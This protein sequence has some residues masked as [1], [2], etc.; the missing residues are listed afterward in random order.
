MKNVNRRTFIK[1]GGS[2]AAAG[3]ALAITPSAVT[4]SAPVAP[5]ATLVALPAAA[6]GSMVAYIPDVTAGEISVMVE[7]HEVTVTDHQLV[8]KIAHAL[9]SNNTV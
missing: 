3:A 6:K 9:H 8:A 7:G 4:G 5:A 2:T 1:A